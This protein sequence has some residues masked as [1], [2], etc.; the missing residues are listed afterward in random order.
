[1]GIRFAVETF[2]V[3]ADEEYEEARRLFEYSCS[4]PLASKEHRNFARKKIT[5]G[6][7]GLLKAKNR[8]SK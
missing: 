7:E 3:A 6:H 4:N 8:V 1:V 2:E 5:R